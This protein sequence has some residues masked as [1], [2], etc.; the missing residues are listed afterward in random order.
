MKYALRSALILLVLASAQTASSQTA[1]EVIE[2]SIA[3]MGGRAAFDKIKTR[4]M[5]GTITLNTPGGDLPGTIE[6]LN[7]RPNKLRTLIKADLSQFGAGMLEI[8]Q[9]FDGQSGY[10]LNTL[11]GNRDI[12]GN[13]LENMRNAGFP[14]A[15]LSYKELGFTAK[16]EGREKVGAGEAYVVVLEPKAGSTIRQYIDAETLL[17]VRFMMRV[18]VPELNADIEQTTELAGYHDVDGIKLP[19]KLTSSSSV[20]SFSVDLSTIEH[21]VPV[22]DKLFIKP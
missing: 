15:F 10:L 1:D 17:P 11:Q 20:Q 5:S 4:A 18:N 21:N 22:D 7:A 13:Q 3:A 9:R 8:D 16:L 6:I 2:K 12:T 19:F 14:H